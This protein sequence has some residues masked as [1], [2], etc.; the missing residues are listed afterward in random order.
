VPIPNPHHHRFR[1]TSFGRWN[2]IGGE[3]R[4]LR[5]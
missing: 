2:I 1:P 4:I 5:E 3:H